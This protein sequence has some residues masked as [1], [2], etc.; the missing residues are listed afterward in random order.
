MRGL[1][2]SFIED[3]RSEDGLLQFNRTSR[4]QE[5]EVRTDVRP[6]VVLLLAGHNPRSTALRSIIDNEK[7]DSLADSEAF[8]LSF[9][10]STFAGYALH[11]AC[12]VT[13]EEI[14]RILHH[15]GK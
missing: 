6:E 5:T 14:R 1:S 4:W 7:I 10:V 12:M 2:D 13:L 3:L 8:D 15:D 11:S 9:F